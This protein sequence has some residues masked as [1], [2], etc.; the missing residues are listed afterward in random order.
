VI[1]RWPQVCAAAVT[2]FSFSGALIMRMP[3]E[4]RRTL[5]IFPIFLSVVVGGSLLVFGYERYGWWMIAGPL[6]IPIVLVQ[7]GSRFAPVWLLTLL[8]YV[9][10]IAGVVC[11]DLLLE[12]SAFR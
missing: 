5:F 11:A 9:T 1:D 4:D 6:L 3:R 8:S 2:C 7:I 10:L 12:N